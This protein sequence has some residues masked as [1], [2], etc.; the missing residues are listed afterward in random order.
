MNMHID[1]ENDIL[2]D[3]YKNSDVT[4]VRDMPEIGVV[5][6]EKFKAEVWVHNGRCVFV[7]HEDGRIVRD[8]RK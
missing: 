1:M 3:I 6:G 5:K 4:A 8:E 7:K 2:Y